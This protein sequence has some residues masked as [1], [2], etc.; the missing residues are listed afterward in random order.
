M[1]EEMRESMQDRQEGK[2]DKE[3]VHETARGINRLRITL[4]QTWMRLLVMWKMQ[5]WVKLREDA[6]ELGQKNSYW[7]KKLIGAI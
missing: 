4:I 6:V 3:S 2:M 7:Q 5:V 1:G